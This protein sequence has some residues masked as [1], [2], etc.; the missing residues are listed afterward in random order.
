M[1]QQHAICYLLATYAIHL[2]LAMHA[3]H[4]LLAMCTTHLLLPLH[5]NQLLLAGLE[6]NDG[7]LFDT[8]FNIHASA[9]A[10]DVTLWPHNIGHSNTMH[11]TTRFGMTVA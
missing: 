2:L 4:L 6:L 11:S 7:Q 5:A 8:E 10:S 1:Q 3:T 9:K